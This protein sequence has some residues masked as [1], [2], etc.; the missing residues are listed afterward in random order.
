MQFQTVENNHENII[1][2]T[3]KHVIRSLFLCKKKNLICLNTHVHTVHAAIGQQFF[4]TIFGI[5][6]FFART[7]LRILF[8]AQRASGKLVTYHISERLIHRH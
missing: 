6:G 7:C 5:V 2:H 8:Q 4:G 3:Q 1:R